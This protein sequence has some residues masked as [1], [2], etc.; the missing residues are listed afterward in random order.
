MHFNKDISEQQ[1]VHS[2]E[3]IY[4]VLV[5]VFSIISYL[6]FFFSILGIILFVALIGIMLFFHVLAM[7]GIRRNGVKIGENQFPDLYA[8]SVAV[9][10]DLGLHKTPDIYVLESEG[11]LNAFATRF[12]RRNMVVLYS[13]IFELIEKD[14]E[15]EV[16]FILAHEFTHLKRKHVQIGSWILP[17]LWIPF[18][19]NA[20]LRACEYTCDRTAAYYVGS[21]EAAKNALTILGIGTTLYKKVNKEAYMEQLENESGF[22]VW[23]HE[24]LSTHPHLPKRL[25]A[26]ESFFKEDTK[27]LVESKKG[28]WIGI[29]FL[30]V[31]IGIIVALIFGAVKFIEKL[32]PLYALSSLEDEWTDTL[33]T[34]DFDYVSIVENGQ[35]NEIMTEG[36]TPLHNAVIM[37]DQENVQYLLENGA[38]PNI[39]DEIYGV[40]PLMDAIYYYEVDISIVEM[41]LDNGSDITMTDPEGYTAYDY[42]LE[43]G[44]DELILLLESYSFQ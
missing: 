22:F 8:K 18:I 33:L 11:M 40:T 38:N 29:V 37:N 34:D 31:V 4:F 24:K 32:E 26:I 23:F 30:V 13:S 28:I 9:A 25:Y 10:K 36:M 1:L 39:P 3:N 16:L 27:R 5:L 43:M 21:F 35:I 42:A 19:G 14:A 41:L 17:A 12:F 7:G 2:K 44:D 15:D 6:F 20:Y